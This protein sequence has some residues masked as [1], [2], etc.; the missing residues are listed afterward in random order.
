[1]KKPSTEKDVHNVISGIQKKLSDLDADLRE[2]STNGIPRDNTMVKGAS[3]MFDTP[4][5]AQKAMDNPDIEIAIQYIK[6]LIDK[7]VK[8]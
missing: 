6:D 3:M 7:N 2:V 4:E 1:V 5:Q 8:K